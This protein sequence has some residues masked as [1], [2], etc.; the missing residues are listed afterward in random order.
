MPPPLRR[1]SECVDYVRETEVGSL[2]VGGL[3]DRED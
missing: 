1:D 3:D 2:Y